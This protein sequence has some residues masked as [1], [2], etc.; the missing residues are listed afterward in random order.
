MQFLLRSSQKLYEIVPWLLF[1]R[2]H[3]RASRS[4]NFPQSYLALERK[5]GLESRGQPVDVHHS[6]VPLSPGCNGRHGVTGGISGSFFHSGWAHLAQVDIPG[7]SSR[8]S[9]FQQNTC[10]PQDLGLGQISQSMAQGP[11]KVPRDGCKAGIDKHFFYP[12]DWS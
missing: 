2:R 11:P 8:P 5:A 10:L 7:V 6:L 12:K 4:V 1:C 9:A 3:W